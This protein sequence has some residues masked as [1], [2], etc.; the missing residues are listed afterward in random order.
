MAIETIV[1]LGKDS[2][3]REPQ[4]APT[5][6]EALIKEMLDEAVSWYETELEPAQK[7]ATDYYHGRPFGNEEEG[8]SRVV[9]PE[10][11]D[12]VKA[13]LPSLMRIFFGPER[14]VEYRPRGPEDEQLSRQQTDYV[15]YMIREDNPGFL[16]FW[17]AFKDALVR[18]LGVIKWWW[19]DQDHVEG[20]EFS[21]KTAAEVA[22]LSDSPDVWIVDLRRDPPQEGYTEPTFSGHLRRRC[23]YGRGRIEAVP[24]EEIVWSPGARSLEDADMVA[25]VRDVPASD[26]IEMGVPR[27]IV[28]RAR[29][30]SRRDE[31]FDS[32]HLASARR[33]DDG[34]TTGFEDVTHPSRERVRYAEVYAYVDLDNDGVAELRLFQCVGPECRIVNGDGEGEIVSERPFALFGPDPEPHTMVGLSVADSVMD[35]QK[36]KSAVLRGVLDSLSLSLFPVTEIVEGEVNPQDVMNTEV[37]KIVRVRRP[38]MMREIPTQFMGAQALPVLEYLDDVKE[39]RTGISKAAAGL[40]ADALQS[41]TKAAVAAT[42][43]AAQQQI[44]LIARI[45]AETGMKQLF[46]GLLRLVVQHQ[47][48]PRTVRLRN[49]WVMIDPRSWDADKDVIVNAALGSG[50]REERM[51]TLAAIAEKQEAQLMAG[52]PLVSFVE[53]R[54]TLGRL[55][56]LAGYND[57]NEF[58]RPWTEQDEQQA[59][60]ARAQ[61]SPP[62]DPAM[63]MAQVEMMKVQM[64]AE[65]AREEI[66]LREMEIQLQ[67]DRERDRTARE[68]ALKEAELELKYATQ[69]NE[70]AL[71][72][73]IE[74]DRAAMDA[75]N[76][77]LQTQMQAQVE[78][79]RMAHEAGQSERDRQ[80]QAQLAAAQSPTE[81]GGAGE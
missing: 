14:V 47:D 60:Q 24:P 44:E 9:I 80:Y 16:T 25:H 18:K 36:I 68:M 69:I 21:G 75:V 27:E 50:T 28:E 29:G 30:D 40:D 81:N 70:A 13:I 6:T 45:F 57:S 74:S 59:Q 11:R 41:S 78:R 67:D 66:R 43:S 51:A 39:N 65:K 32:G 3:E 54:R 55:V 2:V 23:R 56:E 42:L 64:Q 71:A 35:L 37:G 52:S 7:E 1:V 72:H 38:G 17:S 10:V 58:F 26:L 79:E 20:E 61:Q 49:E 5:E 8:R 33:V 31:S 76:T 15:N 63:L 34:S 73:R 48:E 12:T 53:Y 19:Q 4:D 46:R 22:L 62:A 77:H